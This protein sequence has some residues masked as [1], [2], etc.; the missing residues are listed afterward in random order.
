MHNNWQCWLTICIGYYNNG[1][2]RKQTVSKL[3]ESK[4]S[5]NYFH[6]SANSQGTCRWRKR[7]TKKLSITVS[8]NAMTYPT[9]FS[10]EGNRWIFRTPKINYKLSRLWYNKNNFIQNKFKKIELRAIKYT[11]HFSLVQ[12]FFFFLFFLCF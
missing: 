1:L 7:R 9:L 4:S 12:N 5:L 11:K 3:A 6:Q 8:I 2:N 10:P